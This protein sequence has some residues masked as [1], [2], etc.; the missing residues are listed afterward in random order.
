M[1]AARWSRVL[2]SMRCLI[3]VMLPVTDCV[4]IRKSSCGP[5]P[6]GPRPSRSDAPRTDRQHPA[7]RSA[8][9]AHRR[10]RHRFRLAASASP[11]LPLP[12]PPGRHRRD[13]AADPRGAPGG[14]DDDLVAG[15]DTA[16]R[17]RCRHSRES[18]IGP[19]HPLHRKPERL[20]SLFRS[21]VDPFERVEQAG[22]SYQ[23]AWTERLMMLSPNRAE[24]GIAAIEVK[25][26]SAAKL[27]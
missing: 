18:R 7:A 24:I 23:P 10:D 14:G 25:P 26:R 9:P 19:V 15:G 8:S 17:R 21:D 22:P 2:T 1:V 3:V 13:D 16:G 27:S 6:S 4:P 12:P 5:G 11:R 20:A